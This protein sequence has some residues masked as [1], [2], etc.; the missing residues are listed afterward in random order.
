MKGFLGLVQDEKFSKK[1]EVDVGTKE[2][3]R[4]LLV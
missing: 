2:A 3:V 4:W 1:Y